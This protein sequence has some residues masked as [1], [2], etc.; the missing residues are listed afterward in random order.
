MIRQLMTI[1]LA[2]ALAVVVLG[3]PGQAFAQ[4]AVLPALVL[5]DDD[6]E[7]IGPI[8]GFTF[9]DED[10]FP[11]LRLTDP[12]NVV[13]V[14]VTVLDSSHL[15]T[16]NPGTFF[17]GSSCSGTPYHEARIE[18]GLSEISGHDYSV[19]RTGAP[20]TGSQL[21]YVSST[22]DSG[23]LTSYGSKYKNTG[24]NLVGGTTTLREATSV[25]DIDDAHPPPYALR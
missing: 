2:L 1:C 25:L 15:T 8:V 23:S 22:S 9:G 6:G 3:G 5:E 24:C 18:Q 14:L 4:T 21:L 20:S 13:H 16:R 12:I 19:G 7:V 17:S 11:I 10:S